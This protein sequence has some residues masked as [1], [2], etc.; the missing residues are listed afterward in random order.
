MNILKHITALCVLSAPVIAFA[1]TASGTVTSFYAN[2]G[3]SNVVYVTLSGVKTGNPACSTSAKGQFVIP[4]TVANQYSY[5]FTILL[6]AK[7]TGQ[8]VTITGQNQCNV[9]NA[10]ETIQDAT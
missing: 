8:S 7:E 6:N 3:N 2:A 9:D 1:G 4:V 10:V 5:M